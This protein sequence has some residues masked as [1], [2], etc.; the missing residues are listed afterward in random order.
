MTGLEADWLVYQ[1]FTLSW[2]SS[3]RLRCVSSPNNRNHAQLYPGR[4]FCWL[5][6]IHALRIGK[7]LNVMLWRASTGTTSPVLGLRPTRCA[8]S[9]T[10]KIPNEDSFTVSPVASV[11]QISSRVCLTKR[12]KTFE[13]QEPVQRLLLPVCD[14]LFDISH[15]IHDNDHDTNNTLSR[16]E[17]VT[18]GASHS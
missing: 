5:P 3:N 10:L 13:E 2:Y 7:E 8:L 18:D 17:Y 6:L 4:G 12:S 16:S 11:L 14:E 9:R 15:I 1:Q